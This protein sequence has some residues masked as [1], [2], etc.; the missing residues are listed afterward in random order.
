[1]IVL[2]LACA[3]PPVVVAPDPGVWIEDRSVDEGQPVVLHAPA[4]TELPALTTLTVTPRALGDDGSAVWELRGDP[5]AYVVDVPAADGPVRLFFD[6][7][8]EGPTGGPMAELVPY[9]PAPPSR[10][11]WYVA[12]AVAATIVG[13]LLVNMAR[14]LAPAPPPPPPEAPDARARREWRTVRAR[15]DLAPEALALELSSVY[16]RYL[17][18]TERFPATARTTKEILDNLAVDLPAADLDRARRLLSAMDLVKFSERGAAAALFEKFD[19][20]FDAL[21]RA[22]RRAS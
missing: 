13:W 21:V 12:A 15:E 9:S 3:E 18:A 22:R 10:W 7:G 14:R 1:M 20:D 16:R 5:G 2:L 11:P 4:G 8:V 6:I 19:E 17:D